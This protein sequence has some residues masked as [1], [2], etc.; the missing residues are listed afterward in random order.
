MLACSQIS[1]CKPLSLKIQCATANLT[2]A[3][4]VGSVCQGLHQLINQAIYLLLKDAGLGILHCW[5]HGSIWFGSGVCLRSVDGSAL[6]L[7]IF[8]DSNTHI[9]SLLTWCHLFS[10]VFKH[11][12]T[13]WDSQYFKLGRV[14]CA[15]TALDGCPSHLATSIIFRSATLIYALR[16]LWKHA[17]TSILTL[18]HP[19][20]ALANICL[21]PSR[22]TR[23]T[24]SAHLYRH[25]YHVCA[26]RSYRLCGSTNS[27]RQPWN[28]RKPRQWRF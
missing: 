22:A 13:D 16:P 17:I 15:I 11:S 25:S 26:S 18:L 28:V 6:V 2:L 4:S 12:W 1:R 14:Y 7:K 10:L 23:A 19:P 5:L 9:T 21:R 8:S 3:T 20:F 27:E 24:S